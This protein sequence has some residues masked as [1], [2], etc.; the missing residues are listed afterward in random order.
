MGN[1]SLIHLWGTMGW[2][3]R[4]IVIVLALMSF[5]SLTVAVMRWFDLWRSKRQTLKFAPQLNNVLET[6]DFD[7]GE[8][9]VAQYPHSHL[10]AAYRGIFQ[11]LRHHVEDKTL[12]A[13][14]VA[15]AQRTMELN[16]LEQI[17]RF[18]GGLPVLATVGA[19]A[20]FVGLLGTVMGIVHS[21]ASMAQAGSPGLAGISAGIAEALIT[22]ATGLVVAIPSVWIY[23][24][25]VNRVELV[26]MEID[27]G[28]KGFMDF[29]LQIEARFQRG[30]GL[31]SA[32][33]AAA[34]AGARAGG[35]AVRQEG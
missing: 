20:P 32:D 25:L 16:K 35:A 8:K 10:A 29:L 26:S 31:K 33:K 18:R 9:L 1:M 3:A 21:F 6:Q 24:Y 11:E 28:S 27:Y 22:T 23:N 4:S 12:T 15:S 2:F 14:E 7:T 13:V 5:F 19:T 17:A 34:P 30:L